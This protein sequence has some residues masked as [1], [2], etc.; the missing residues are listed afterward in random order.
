MLFLKPV[1][2]FKTEIFLI[3]LFCKIDVTSHVNRII[4][5]DLVMEEV[6]V[7]EKE[8]FFKWNTKADAFREI[9]KVLGMF[10]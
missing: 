3:F 2:G 5:I 7:I 1:C 6:L 9:S 10:F 8:V 4:K